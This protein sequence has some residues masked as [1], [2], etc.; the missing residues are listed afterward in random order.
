MVGSVVGQVGTPAGIAAPVG[1][2]VALAARRAANC[3]GVRLLLTER[4]SAA[5]PETIG[6]EKLVPRFGFNSSV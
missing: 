3:A 6:A 2:G 4:I 1:K 5:M